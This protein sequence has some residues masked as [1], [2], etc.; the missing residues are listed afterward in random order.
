MSFKDMITKWISNKNQDVTL[1]IGLI[2]RFTCT[3]RL[4][5]YNDEYI[6]LDGANATRVYIKMSAVETIMVVEGADHV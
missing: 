6:I 3:G 2:S 1:S 5:D 4:I